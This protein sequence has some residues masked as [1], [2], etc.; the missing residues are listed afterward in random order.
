MLVCLGEVGGTDEYAIVEA[1]KK[2]QI[3]KPLVIWVTGTCAKAFKTDVQFGHAGARAKS[4]T[5]SAHAKN[6]ALK[7]AGAVVPYSFDD[8]DEA[9]NR[10]YR[11]LVEQ[12][13]NTSAPNTSSTQN[14]H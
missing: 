3:T 4:D 10:V 11:K 7:E 1:L 5:E 8:Y 13:S 14:A 2:K 9:I 12:G 6:V